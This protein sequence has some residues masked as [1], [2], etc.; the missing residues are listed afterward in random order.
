[1]RFFESRTPIE[2]ASR[3]STQD[4]LPELLLLLLNH[5]VSRLIY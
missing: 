5:P 4:S 3:T 2:S 1:L